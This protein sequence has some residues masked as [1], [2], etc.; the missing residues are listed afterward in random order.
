MHRHRENIIRDTYAHTYMQ[1]YINVTIWCPSRQANI[2]YV[3]TQT[4]IHTY[5]LRT[6][7]ARTHAYADTCRSDDFTS[8]QAIKHPIYVCTHTYTHITHAHAH[9]HIHMLIHTEVT[10]P[11]PSRHANTL[12]TNQSRVSTCIPVYIKRQNFLFW[13]SVLSRSCNAYMQTHVCTY[14]MYACC[15]CL[16]MCVCVYACII[17]TFRVCA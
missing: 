17:F 15:D 8:Q 4:Y 1:T 12:H 11:C 5:M 3:C 16:C 7:H 14:E 9:T 2:L 6:H 13:I 10:I